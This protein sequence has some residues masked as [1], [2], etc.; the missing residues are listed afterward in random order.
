MRTLLFLAGFATLS[1]L[2]CSKGNMKTE[3]VGPR[4]TSGLYAAE[5]PADKSVP[6][7]S[8]QIAD[9]KTYA[10]TFLQYDCEGK[11]SAQFEKSGTTFSTEP[12]S[13][14]GPSVFVA[15]KKCDVQTEILADSGT[16]LRL[17]IKLNG[18]DQD[19]YLLSKVNQDAFIQTVKTQAAKADKF[20]VEEDACASLGTTCAQVELL[21]K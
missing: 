2:G 17:K 13:A 21:N 3:N 11:T 1:T 5:N 4:I 9:G 15:G 6:A 19:A 20:S 16:T 7:V 14:G 12:V 10:Y 8:I 18:V